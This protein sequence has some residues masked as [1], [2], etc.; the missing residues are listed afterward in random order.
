MQ[1]NKY[2]TIDDAINKWDIAKKQ[3]VTYYM[4]MHEDKNYLHFNISHFNTIIPY[5]TLH[6]LY[7]T[8]P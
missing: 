3:F 2:V 5:K 6:T 1:S 4:F 7:F 8:L